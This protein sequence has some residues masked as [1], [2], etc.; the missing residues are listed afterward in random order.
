M[1]T[2]FTLRIAMS[3]T[4]LFSFSLL[5]AQTTT[6]ATGA[7]VTVKTGATGITPGSIVINSGGA[8]DNA[9]TLQLG[10]DWTNNGSGLINASTGNVTFNGSVLQN[11]NGSNSTTFYDVTLNNSAGAVI[12]LNET[13]SHNLAL[14]SGALDINGNTL[15]VNGAVS[16]TGTLSGSATS[17]LTLGGAAGSISFTP[18]SATLKDLTINT[19]ASATL[20][21]PLDI[22]AGASAG[23]VTVNGTGVLTTG[24]N[25][26]L[27]S[28]ANGTARVGQ[29][30]TASYIS[31]T[32][33]VERYISANGGNRAWRLL[34]VPTSGQTINA[35][36]QE[37][38]MGGV[39][40]ISGFGTLIT[41]P[42]AP[43]GANGEDS[44][45]PSS[46]LGSFSGGAWNWLSSTMVP[47]ATK[48][49]YILYIRGD[50]NIPPSSSTTGANSTVLRT[51]G[52]L[53]EGPQVAIA[54]AGNTLVGNVYAST[55]DFAS[56]IRAGISNS[57]TIW[58]PALAG[59][60]NLGAYQT[61]SP[62]PGWVP[63]GGNYPAASP[64][65]I[66]SGQA[67]FVS[68]TGTITLTEASKIATSRSV[69][70]PLAAQAT[71]RTNLYAVESPANQ[72]ADGNAVVF[73]NAYSDNIDQDDAVKVDNFGENLGM[74][75]NATDL[76]VEKRQSITRK[77]T[78][79]YNMSNLRQISYL[80]EFVPQNISAAGLSATLQDSYLGTSTPVDLT[81]TT[82]QTFTVTSNAATSA[83][84]R[85]R[86][87]F[88]QDGA[89]PL[90]FL[91]LTATERPNGIQLNWKV[92]NETGVDHYE[93]ERSLTGTSFGKIN[94][95]VVAI[96]SST[97]NMLDAS[98]NRGVNFYR[99]KAVD[100]SGAIRYTAVVKVILGG[101]KGIT[102]SPNPITGRH[103]SLQFSNEPAGAY[104]I[105]ITNTAGQLMYH[106][107]V[108]H[109]GGNS[110]QGIDL[111]K[112][113]PGTYQVQTTMPD[114]TNNV[115]Q[116]IIG[117]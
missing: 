25:L 33:T 76:I 99:I 100:A 83:A 90:S 96:G 117:N 116:I 111:P 77:D 114:N 6:I 26:T 47:I 65:V 7:T 86:L 12:G 29:G 58:D 64:G 53:Y 9:G 61:W 20:G 35:A 1:I 19:G 8:I 79:F 23:S 17:N 27:K 113:A 92:A 16:G 18:G 109:D 15:T 112:V 31:G 13:I 63:G 36:W 10:T 104:S 37:G 51:K 60:Y 97:Y 52:S 115:Q 88:N 30:T 59:S 3:C 49:G 57:F 106:T 34:S 101:V 89:L 105:S 45:Q 71:I 41:S 74:I 93:A 4:A 43:T 39:V 85:F 66:Q 42:A 2:K 67:F 87:V 82:T 22:T 32:V 56:I 5:H 55:I 94:N 95:N 44:Q 68:G 11:I 38:F 78:I 81:T 48:S 72:L 21:S 108:N 62:G 73:D 14:T 103:I 50:R 40:G 70:T 91:G 28:D 80:L 69:F 46:S 24:G 102:I 107:T 75:R 110:T 84:N 98:P 54:V